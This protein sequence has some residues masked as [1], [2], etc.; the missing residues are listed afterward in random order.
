MTRPARSR[1]A[2]FPAA[3]AF[4]SVLVSETN[5]GVQSAWTELSEERVGRSAW[6]CLS[7]QAAPLAEKRGLRQLRTEP[8]LAAR[9]PG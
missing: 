3:G 7:K 5:P 4:F 6:K 1:L 8:A 2:L 9:R